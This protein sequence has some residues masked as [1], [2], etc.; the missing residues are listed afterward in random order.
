MAKIFPVFA[1]VTFRTWNTYTT[2]IQKLPVIIIMNCISCQKLKTKF[3]KTDT[4]SSANCKAAW[5]RRANYL[6]LN[7]FGILCTAPSWWGPATDHGPKTPTL[8]ALRLPSGRVNFSEYRVV[9]QDLTKGSRWVLCLTS[10]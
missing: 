1:P 9:R 6:N 8:A 2:P 4:R 5:W 10:V 7:Y 3:S